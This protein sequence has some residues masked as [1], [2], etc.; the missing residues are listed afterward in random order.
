M[1]ESACFF[2]GHR[3]IAEAQLNTVRS[4]LSC[5]VMDMI[6]IGVYEFIAGGAVGF[7]MIA[8]ETVVQLRNDYNQLRLLLYLPCGGYNRHWRAEDKQRMKKLIIAADEVRYISAEY[9]EQCMKRRNAAMVRDA[10]HC[11]AW[12]SRHCRGGTTQTVSMAKKA[13]CS[14]RNL[15]IEP[16]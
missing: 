14:I 9:D 11:I 12:H 13:G 16:W 6:N 10:A 2:T 4:A 7:D 1:R 5:A 3:L 8:A 15:A